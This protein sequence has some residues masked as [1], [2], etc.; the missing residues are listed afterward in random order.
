MNMFDPY[1]NLTG[2]LL[3]SSP[4]YKGEKRSIGTLSQLHKIT[5]LVG[6]R[7]GFQSQVCLQSLC[8]SFLYFLSSMSAPA[9]LVKL[10]YPGYLRERMV[11]PASIYGGFQ[12][13]LHECCGMNRP[14]CA[15]TMTDGLVYKDPAP[16]FLQHNS[17]VWVPLFPGGV[18]LQWPL[19]LLAQSCPLDCCL[20]FPSCACLTS[21]LPTEV[22]CT[23]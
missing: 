10:V 17:E 18:E 6:G 5:E 22:L 15:S 14:G 11:F 20:L 7:A 21:L 9:S 3:L 2:E 23:Y 13:L 1:K 16:Y 8:L 19:M 12:N 4:F